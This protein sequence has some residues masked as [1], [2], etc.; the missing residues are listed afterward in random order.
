M[1][2]YPNPTNGEIFIAAKGSQF[3][4]NNSPNSKITNTR[5]S[6]TLKRSILV[7]LYDLSGNLLLSKNFE[8]TDEIPS[9]DLTPFEKAKY[10][11][12]IQSENIDE[13]HQ[14]IKK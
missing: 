11:L 14:I 6:N 2:V 13:I 1:V 4:Q 9:I 10:L 5:K 3:T 12:R 8:K 7:E